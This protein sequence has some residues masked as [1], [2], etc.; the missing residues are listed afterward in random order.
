MFSLEELCELSDRRVPWAPLAPNY[1]RVNDFVRIPKGQNRAELARQVKEFADDFLLA[2]RDILRR[3]ADVM[4]CFEHVDLHTINP[5]LRDLTIIK[6]EQREYA[7]IAQGL[8]VEDMRKR[9]A[10]MRLNYA[11]IA[12][13]INE[14]QFRIIS[15][16]SG[17]TEYNRLEDDVDRR[18][19]LALRLFYWSVIVCRNQ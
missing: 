14:T 12:G 2:R 3:L 16:L 17:K 1:F 8:M 15:G 9:R 7:K 18:D 10:E 4:P 19:V 5:D 6:L 11:M 13:L